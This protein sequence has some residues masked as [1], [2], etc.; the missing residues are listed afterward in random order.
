[1]ITIVAHWLLLYSE[2]N[3]FICN[4]RN[5]WFTLRKFSK[6]YR[7]YNL[8]STQQQGATYLGENYLSLMLDQIEREG[9]SVFVVKGNLPTCKADQR[10][11]VLGRPQAQE[12]NTKPTFTAFTGQGYSLSSNA[13]LQTEEEEDEEVMLAR[14]I[15]VSL[16][17]SKPA[18]D[19]DEIR[20]KRLARFG[21]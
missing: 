11:Q 20:R 14:A 5:H 18:N 10:A 1:M 7:W 3:G 8:D 15:Q 2:Q 16:E 17:D 9:Y 4:L 6:I 13:P 21:A 19:M 12:Q